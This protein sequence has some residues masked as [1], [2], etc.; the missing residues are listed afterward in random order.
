M[1]TQVDGSALTCFDDFI[2]YLFTY[3]GY[4]FFDTCRVDTSV[5]YQLMQCQ[6]S[7]FAANGV[8]CR[9]YDSFRGIV[10][11]DFYTGSGFKGTDVTS[12]TS[13]DTSLDFVR[14]DVEYCY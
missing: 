6:A 2:F 1:D 4:Y 12:F 3:F 8:E 9:K 10:Y 11:Y 5:G 7:Y 13:D 14:F